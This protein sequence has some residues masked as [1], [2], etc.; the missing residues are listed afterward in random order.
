MAEWGKLSDD[1]KKVYTANFKVGPSVTLIT[2][3][4]MQDLGPTCCLAM[5][6][7]ALCWEDTML[8]MPRRLKGWIKRALV[9][10]DCCRGLC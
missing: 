7:S 8:D 9:A 3:L 4:L 5:Q 2:S 1:E 6:L 10:V